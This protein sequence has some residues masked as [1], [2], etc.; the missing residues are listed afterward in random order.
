MSLLAIIAALL[1]SAFQFPL[2]KD[3]VQAPVNQI[4]VCSSGGCIDGSVHH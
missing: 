2:F 4:N 3:H 1:V